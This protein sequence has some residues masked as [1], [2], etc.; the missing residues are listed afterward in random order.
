LAGNAA[1]RKTL[2]CQIRFELKRNG[3]LEGVAMKLRKM[4]YTQNGEKRQSEKWYAVWVDH[5][6]TLRRVPLFA[7]RK[8]SD[9][10][11]Y[12]ID[13]L[14]SVRAS[15]GILPPELSR[16]VEQMPSAIRIKLANWGF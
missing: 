9:E 1:K 4:T 6:E 14:N 7:D 2:E 13:K 16:F 15:D 12:K 10:I 3:S 11:A 5:S 8:A